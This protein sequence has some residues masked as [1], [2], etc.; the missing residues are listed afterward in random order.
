MGGIT[1]PLMVAVLVFTL[2]LPTML[3]LAQMWSQASPIITNQINNSTM[4]SSLKTQAINHIT[5]LGNGFFYYTAPGILVLLYF[6]LIL[7]VFISALY[8]S[9]HPE[10]L[11]IGMLFLIVLIIV[12]LPLTDLTHYFYTN[13]GFATVAPYYKSIEYLSDNSPLLTAL[14]TFGYLLF[15]STKKMIFGSPGGTQSTSVEVH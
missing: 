13:S 10:T 14:A 6:M 15:I 1:G 8:E 11:P 4:N 9:A 7:A 3:I 12:T 2:L 5:N